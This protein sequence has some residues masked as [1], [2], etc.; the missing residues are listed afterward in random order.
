MSTRR[1]TRGADALELQTV[2]RMLFVTTTLAGVEVSSTRTCFDDAAADE[3]L[4]ALAAERT[5]EGWVERRAPAPPPVPVRPR[6]PR[7]K[8]QASARKQVAAQLKPGLSRKSAALLARLLD[9]ATFRLDLEPGEDW[10]CTFPAP[11]VPGEAPGD[12]A[13]LQL[14]IAQEPARAVPEGI[15]APLEKLLRVCGG[16]A[17]GVRGETG[18]LVLHDGFDGTLGAVGDDAL[19]ARATGFPYSADLCAPIDVDL[20]SFYLVHPTTGRLLYCDSEG[21]VEP[22]DTDDPVEAY[23]RELVARFRLA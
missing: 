12:E 16:M 9:H 22:A 17:C 15:P 2:G 18:Q 14:E 19:N 7:P 11:E 20:Q 3:A 23:L 10:R 4:A 5:E 6:P 21:T 13:D 8:T 1:F